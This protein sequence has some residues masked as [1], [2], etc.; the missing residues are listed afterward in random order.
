MKAHVWSARAG[1]SRGRHSSQVWRMVSSTVRWEHERLMG[2]HWEWHLHLGAH[3]MWKVSLRTCLIQ[4]C[5]PYREKWWIDCRWISAR[6]NTGWTPCGLSS[7]CGANWGR[8]NAARNHGHSQGQSYLASIYDTL[9]CSLQ[10]EKN[11]FLKE[12]KEQRLWSSF[13]ILVVLQHLIL[14]I[15]LLTGVWHDL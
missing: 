1:Q 9:F 5:L 13:L 3:G 15:K 7:T 12:Q 4:D 11:C 6:R 10:K 2:K 14:K 8:H